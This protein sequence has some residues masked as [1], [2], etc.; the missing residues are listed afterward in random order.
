MNHE[1]ATVRPAV[2]TDLG[3]K[4]LLKINQFSKRRKDEALSLAEIGAA[5]VAAANTIDTQRGDWV[6]IPVLTELLTDPHMREVALERYAQDEKWGGEENDDKNTF[7]GWFCFI[8]GKLEKAADA[9]VSINGSDP[10]EY[11]RRMVQV[12]ALA[13][14]AVESLDRQAQQAVEAA[15]AERAASDGTGYTETEKAACRNRCAEFGDP[16]CFTLTGDNPPCDGC[17][18]KAA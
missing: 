9:V 2:V 3:N 10:A 11:R 6:L 5:M 4:I 12:A 7:Q 16:P 1:Q 13:V 14:A 15:Q 17:K 8:D 18:D